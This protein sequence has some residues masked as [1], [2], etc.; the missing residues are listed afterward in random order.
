MNSKVIIDA[1]L[2]FVITFSTSVLALLS[3]S[4]VDNLSQISQSSYVAAFLGA[5]VATAKVVQSRLTDSPANIKQTD[6]IVSAVAKLDMPKE[7]Q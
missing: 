5:V 3:Q 7:S 2:G 6:A 4:G 1:F